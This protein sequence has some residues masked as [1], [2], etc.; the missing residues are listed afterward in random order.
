M[1]NE[2]S[3]PPMSQISF[4]EVSSSRSTVTF[5]PGSSGLT[6]REVNE[7]I[8]KRVSGIV[9][10]LKITEGKRLEAARPARFQAPNC[11]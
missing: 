3:L 11:A 4:S 2:S 10:D 8:E 1:S 5:Q 7:I 9:R 6:E